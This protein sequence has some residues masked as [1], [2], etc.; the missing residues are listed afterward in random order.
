MWIAIA[1]LAAFSILLARGRKDAPGAPKTAAAGEFDEIFSR[2]P[3]RGVDPQ[4]HPV[5][6]AALLA[7]GAA[8]T[9]TAAQVAGEGPAPTLG[10]TIA[11]IV[12]FMI[13]EGSVVFA[14]ILTI[15]R[16][17]GLVGPLRR[18]P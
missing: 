15:G 4:A 11:V 6:F 5:R 9:V 8:V 13:I 16:W 3:L 17:L 18:S 12:V 7:A 10:K 1:L 2:V 14:G